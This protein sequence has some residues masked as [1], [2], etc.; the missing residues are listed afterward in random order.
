MSHTIWPIW[1]DSYNMAI[2]DRS[3]NQ[4]LFMTRSTTLNP[5]VKSV[6]VNSHN[7]TIHFY[8]CMLPLRSPCDMAVKPG[9][10]ALK[11]WKTIY[12][13]KT[14]QS[15]LS[16][17]SVS[18]WNQ[19]NTYRNILYIIYSEYFKNRFLIKVIHFRKF[20]EKILCVSYDMIASKNFLWIASNDRGDSMIL[21]GPLFV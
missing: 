15:R 1:Y 9:A 8:F 10:V 5:T 14:V 12:N 3:V 2:V 21:Y 17:V 16:L 19:I 13:L 18:G 20:D 7:G 11:S 6:L 4:T